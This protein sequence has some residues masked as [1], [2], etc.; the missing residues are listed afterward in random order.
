MPMNF[1]GFPQTLGCCGGAALRESRKAGARAKCWYA[2][3]VKAGVAMTAPYHQYEMQ[4]GVERVLRKRMEDLF[5]LAQKAR[6]AG[7]KGE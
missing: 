3:A 7:F 5:E 4:G 1:P 2:A 6:A